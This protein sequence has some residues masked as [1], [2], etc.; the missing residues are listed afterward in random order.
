MPGF[1][2][3]Q[4]E[5]LARRLK[6]RA[7]E[8]GFL[9]CGISTAGPLDQE[10]RDLEAWLNQGRHGTMK[11]MENHFDKRIDPTLLVP[12]ARSVVSVLHNY[13]PERQPPAD[14][15]IGRISRYAWGDDYHSVMKERLAELFVWLG[16]EVGDISGRVFVDSAPVMDKAWARRSG[17]GWIGKHTNLITRSVGS[18]YFIGEMIIDVPLPADGPDTDHCGTCTRCIDACPT[19]AI[20]APYQLDAARCISYLTIEHRNETLPEE[21]AGDI[22]NWIYGCD[23]CQEVCPWNRFAT[24]TEEPRYATRT[25]LP[26]TSLEA[27]EELDTAGF[28]ALFKGSAAKRAKYAMFM[29]N[30]RNALENRP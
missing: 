12:G 22:G 7:Q 23:I 9:A 6:Q 28:R 11:W 20:D 8:L 15:D 29:R 17:L 3:S 14:P 25:G 2:A 10:A 21:T 26:D 30:V 19:D 13:Y 16:D 18:W 4:Q 5:R 24:P 27:W 1:D